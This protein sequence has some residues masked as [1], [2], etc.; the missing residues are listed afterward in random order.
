MRDLRTTDR[1]VI[2]HGTPCLF[3]EFPDGCQSYE[4]IVFSDLK[5]K[6]RWWTRQAEL[7]L[8]INVPHEDKLVFAAILNQ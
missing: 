8:D 5:D 7:R 2:C 4:P 3:T 1:L 6:A